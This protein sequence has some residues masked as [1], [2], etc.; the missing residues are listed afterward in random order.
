MCNLPVNS[1][2]L[3]WC[4]NYIQYAVWMR[5]IRRKRRRKR[6]R[7]RGGRGGGR[8]GERGASDTWLMIIGQ[9]L[10]DSDQTVDRVCV[11]VH[12]LSVCV[13][14]SACVCLREDVKYNLEQSPSTRCLLHWWSKDYLNKMFQGYALLEVNI[15][16]CRVFYDSKQFKIRKTGEMYFKMAFKATTQSCALPTELLWRYGKFE[17]NNCCIVHIVLHVHEIQGYLIIH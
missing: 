6:R 7:R 3:V 8:G 16:L 17:L 15:R 14:L 1:N 10:D 5:R 2:W 12:C 9:Q 11:Y 4:S 13:C